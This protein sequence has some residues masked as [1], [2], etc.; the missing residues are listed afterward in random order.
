MVRLAELSER[1][2]SVAAA[3]HEGRWTRAAEDALLAAG[4]A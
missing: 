2:P 4:T 3:L 1:L